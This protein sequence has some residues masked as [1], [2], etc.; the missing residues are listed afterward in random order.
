[1]TLQFAAT[2]FLLV[3]FA[4]FGYYAGYRDGDREGYTRG[5][6][7]GSEVTDKLMA[8]MEDLDDARNPD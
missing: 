7:E 6:F 8:S 2:S 5:Y 3:F 1:M 4:A